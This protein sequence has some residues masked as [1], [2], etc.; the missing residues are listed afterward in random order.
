MDE[1][2]KAAFIAADLESP[3]WRNEAWG[4]HS[5]LLD[6]GCRRWTETRNLRSERGQI[7]LLDTRQYPLQSLQ[8]E[9]AL[10]PGGR[11]R[12]LDAYNSAMVQSTA[13]AHSFHMQQVA[14]DQS[15]ERFLFA[16]VSQQSFVQGVTIETEAQSQQ[17]SAAPHLGDQAGIPAPESLQ[18]FLQPRTVLR[19]TADQGASVFFQEIERG[20]PGPTGKGVSGESG[21]VLEGGFIVVCRGGGKAGPDRHETTAQSLGD[22]HDI[23]CNAELTAN[24]HCSGPAETGLDLIGN[25]NRAHVAAGFSSQSQITRGRFNDASFTLHGLDQETGIAASG[26]SPAQCLDIAVGHVVETGYRGAEGLL[27]LF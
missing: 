21:S 6:L 25:K 17:I 20:E 7:A 1:E 23:R 22:R 5:R 8:E 9:L 18:S 15:G 26:Q 11:E 12:R 24:E 2:R 13:D 19:H 16:E 14:D 27:V 3:A 4:F 10:F